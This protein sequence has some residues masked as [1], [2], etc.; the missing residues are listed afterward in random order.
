MRVWPI[1]TRI[2][3]VYANYSEQRDRREVFYRNDATLLAQLRSGLCIHLQ[4]Y[5]H[6]IDNSVDRNCFRWGEA[7]HTLEHW[8]GCPGT[9]QV[10]L[11]IFCTT[12]SLPVSTV[13]TFPGKSVALARGIFCDGLVRMPSASRTTAAALVVL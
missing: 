7:P 11:E 12:E 4:D 8:L 10:R 9:L 13:T 3:A 1:H 5:E 6:L 2:A